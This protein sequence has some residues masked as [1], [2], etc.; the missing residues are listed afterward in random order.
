M[1]VSRMDLGER[2][3]GSPMA[4]VTLILKQEPNLP[5]PVPIRRLCKQLDIT[6]IRPLATKGFEGGLITDTDR[7]EGIILVNEDSHDYR[8]NFTLGHELGHFLIPTHMPDKDGRFL[9]SR[10][11]MALL[12]ASEND[13]R[14]RMEVEA[15]QFASLLLIPPPALRRE[16]GSS[17][18][19]L[20]RLVQLANKFEVSKR[21]MARAYTE[22]HEQPVAVVAVKDGQVIAT[23]RNKVRFPFIQ[24]SIGAAVPAGSLYRRARLQSG[25]L[26]NFSEC[27]PDLWIEVRRGVRAPTM[28]EQVLGQRDGYALI[29]LHLEPQAENE[30]DDEELLES[31]DRRFAR[32]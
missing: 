1:P 22:Y 5:V 4:L 26:S 11:D 31:T 20:T 10:E 28:Y 7:S 25:A 30:D 9:C 21:A 24:P 32:R 16:L 27:V 8:K 12:S 13:R 3:A 19:D 6:E 14:A 29:L 2:N 17:S 18:P 15:N 23:Y